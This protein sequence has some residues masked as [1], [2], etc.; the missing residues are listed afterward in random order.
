MHKHL[1]QRTGIPP[2]TLPSEERQVTFGVVARRVVQP[3]TC[4]ATTAGLAFQR[5]DLC[6]RAGHGGSFAA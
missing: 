3:R 2:Y 5:P 6:P 4:L 1:E